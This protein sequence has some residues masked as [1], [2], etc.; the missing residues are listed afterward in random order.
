MEL[1][2]YVELIPLPEI[3]AALVIAAVIGATRA[4]FHSSGLFRQ[5]QGIIRPPADEM[6]EAVRLRAR[7]IASCVL[8][9]TIS[10]PLILRLVPPNGVYGFRIALTR[11]N[12]AI[13]YA[14]NAFMGWALL[15]AAVAGATLVAML[16]ATVKRWMVW[17]AFFVPVFGAIVAS[18]LYATRL[19]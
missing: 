1:E 13:W 17:A 6:T 8:L 5:R 2:R 11:S 3:I 10:V 15:L 12:P 7:L 9:A 19:R 18:F 4:L 16:P 14:A